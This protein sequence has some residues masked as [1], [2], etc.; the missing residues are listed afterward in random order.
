MAFET[1]R[2]FAELPRGMAQFDLVLPSQHFGS[3]RKQEPEHRLMRAVLH[4]ALDCL[5][6]YRHVGSRESLAMFHD[7]ET[8]FLCRENEWPYS[9][10]SICGVLDLDADAVR[11]SLHVV[12]RSACA[13]T[14][15]IDSR[16][17]ASVGS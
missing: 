14:P 13:T 6:K 17:A 4:D 10:E 16:R 9:F 1:T 3:P 11:E 15:R 2:Q 5:A 8:W 7:A 12:P